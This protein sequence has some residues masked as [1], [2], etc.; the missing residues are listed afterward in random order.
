MRH[1]I[2]CAVLIVLCLWAGGLFA[3]S[4][5]YREASKNSRE[6]SAQGRYGEAEPFARRALVTCPLQSGP[7]TIL[8]WTKK[9][10]SDGQET[11]A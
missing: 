1:M 9:E 3:Q 4:A 8:V 5:D 10:K 2:G 6:L 7:S 11:R